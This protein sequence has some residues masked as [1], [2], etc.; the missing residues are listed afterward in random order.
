MTV[1]LHLSYREREWYY[2]IVEHLARSQDGV[3]AFRN[4]GI[5]DQD[6]NGNGNVHPRRPFLAYKDIQVQAIQQSSKS[7]LEIPIWSN[8]S[9]QVLEYL[10]VTREY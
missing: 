8:T 10:Y 9:V 5:V 3:G 4:S 7:A 1:F 6:G 2:G